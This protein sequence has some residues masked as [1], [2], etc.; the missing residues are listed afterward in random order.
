[1]Y[2]PYGLELLY[3]GVLGMNPLV[4]HRELFERKA[5]SYRARRPSLGIAS[6]A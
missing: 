4:P 1:L 2:A 5:A 6:A 3:E